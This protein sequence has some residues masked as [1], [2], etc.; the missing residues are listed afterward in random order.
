L[1]NIIPAELASIDGCTHVF[2]TDCI[3]E[4][5]DQENSCPN[6]KKRFTTIR[7]GPISHT[8]TP[9]NQHS[10]LLETMLGQL[11]SA[12]YSWTMLNHNNNNTVGM[13]PHQL[14]PGPFPAGLAGL[15]AFGPTAQHRMAA[16][17]G[18]TTLGGVPPPHAH[19]TGLAG[20]MSAAAAAAG[21]GAAHNG[22]GG[23]A[24]AS[25]VGDTVHSLRLAL[26]LQ[27]RTSAAAMRVVT[28]TQQQ[29]QNSVRLSHWLHRHHQNGR[30]YANPID[31]TDD[32]S[33]VLL[34][35]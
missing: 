16:G 25:S 29:Q 33:E 1:S 3:T 23:T 18:R 35:D 20:W 28:T 34:V 11:A 12:H 2:C 27:A 15:A 32:G 10:D 8:V 17:A 21:P 7:N 24:A 22:G 4:W 26:S 13:M 31:I 9:R 14:L 30:S 19:A 6:C 5:S